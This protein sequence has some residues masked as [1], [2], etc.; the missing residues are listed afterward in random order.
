MAF[1]PIEATA[2]GNE[3]TAV[4]SYVATLPAGI[5]S[6]NLLV[7]SVVKK[8]SEALDAITGWTTVLDYNWGVVGFGRLA[9]LARVA[10]GTEGGSVTITHTGTARTYAHG[11][12]RITDWFGTLAGVEVSV[13]ATASSTSP[14]PP[15]LNPAGWDVEDT[16]WLV[17]MGWT[18]G[19]GPVTIS[20][21]PTNYTLSQTQNNSGTGSDRCGAA[22]AGQNLAAAS[23]DPG[24]FTLSAGIDWGA[25]TVA[26]RPAAAAGGQPATKR[27]GGTP[28][29]RGDSGLWVP[30]R[31]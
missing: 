19:A 24:T 27:H 29:A 4:N 10:D 25:I 3:P 30:K 21:W 5:V 9:I 18:R 6:G 28:Y 1:P 7:A 13:G 8:N 16:L 14:D 23:E 20:A 31:W 17:A 26:I 11:A 15:V 12:Y 2:S 22:L